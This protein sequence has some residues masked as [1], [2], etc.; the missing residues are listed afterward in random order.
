MPADVKVEKD[1][2]VADGRVLLSLV[3]GEGQFGRTDVRLNTVRLLRA[4]GSIGNLVVGAGP[5][6]V[7]KTL[8]VR[9]VVLDTVA[10]TNRMSVTY[11]LS[12]GTQT[13]EF[14]ARG[15]VASEGGNLI[16]EGNFDLV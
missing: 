7:G 12:G 10:A 1:Y 5:D 6:V 9:S 3:I 16:F 11:K 2:K 13:K 4:S 8:K 15:T 14:V